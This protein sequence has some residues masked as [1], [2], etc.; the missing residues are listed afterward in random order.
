[1]Y[2]MVGC[3]PRLQLGMLHI[4]WHVQ[5]ISFLKSE[6]FCPQGFWVRT[7]EP[8]VSQIIFVSLMK[9]FSDFDVGESRHHWAWCVC[10]SV[11]KEKKIFNSRHDL[12]LSIP[13]ESSGRLATRLCDTWGFDLHVLNWAQRIVLNLMLFSWCVFICSLCWYVYSVSSA[14]FFL[15]WGY[16]LKFVCLVFVWIDYKARWRV[17]SSDVVMWFQFCEQ[18]VFNL[19]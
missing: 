14:F 2:L 7:Y 13:A 6:K 16:F 9:E 11:P 5:C 19:M 3:S 8:V 18:S 17:V 1:M 15:R 10:S 4:I 12:V